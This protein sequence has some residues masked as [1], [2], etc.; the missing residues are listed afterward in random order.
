MPRRTMPSVRLAIPLTLACLVPGCGGEP[1]ETGSGLAGPD[2]L[3]EWEPEELYA[4]GGFDAPEWAT[5]GQVDDVAFD[6]MGNL[7][8]FDGQVSEVTVVSPAGEFIR[9]IGGQGDGPG[10]ISRGLGMTVFPEG[11][12]AISDLG[13]RGLVLYDRDGEWLGNIALDLSKEGLPGP[14][15]AAHPDGWILSA[16]PLRMTV[17][18]P[19][20]E[21]SGPSEPGRRP[22]YMYPTEEGAHAYELFAGWDPPEPGGGEETTMEAGAGDNRVAV[23]MAPLQAFEPGLQIAILPD[24]LVAVVDSTTYRIRLLDPEGEEVG[25]LSRPIE[26]RE[27]T[28]RIQALE[29]ER[30]LADLQEDGGGAV[31]VLGGGNVSFDQAQVRRALRERIESMSFHPEVPVVAALAADGSGRLWVRRSG[32]VPGEPG[33]VDLITPTGDYLGTLPPEGLGIPEAFGPDGLVA[34]R[35]SDAYDVVTI[36]VLRLPVEP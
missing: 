22:V 21:E 2:R 26:P 29:R 3:L 28:E 14:D 9:R 16:Q 17:R 1:Q 12:V 25:A 23:R 31:R 19:G 5:F 30:R 24:G 13:R 18:Q 8:L 36:R 32:A 4:V 11:R 15:M 20:E 6:A 34:I 7:Y 33:P 27:V 35:E 10:E